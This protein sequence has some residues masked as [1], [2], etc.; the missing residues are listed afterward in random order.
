MSSQ[1]AALQEQVFEIACRYGVES[2]EFLVVA[3][4]L[5]FFLTPVPMLASGAQN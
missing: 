2:K 3:D 4:V 1:I 5:A